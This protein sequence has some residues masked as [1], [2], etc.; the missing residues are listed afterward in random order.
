MAWRDA[1]A[2]PRRPV[3]TRERVDRAMGLGRTI[4]ALAVGSAL[5]SACN[6]TDAMIPRVGVGE[7]AT[8][9]NSS[10]VTQDDT[11]RMARAPARQQALSAPSGEVQHGG[12][13]SFEQAQAYPSGSGSATLEEQ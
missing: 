13:Q 1:I 4:S 10:P 6:T 9:L 3:R 11:E 7:D 8:A 5:L 2:P 12:G